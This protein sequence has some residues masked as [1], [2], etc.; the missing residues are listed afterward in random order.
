M[1]VLGMRD[2]PRVA[3]NTHFMYE[4][5]FLEIYVYLSES[6]YIESI[7][8]FCVKKHLHEICRI[9]FKLRSFSVVLQII[10][11]TARRSIP[12]FSPVL[13]LIPLWNAEEPDCRGRAW[14]SP[15]CYL[16]GVNHIPGKKR[17]FL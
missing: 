8:F 4:T 6:I 2:N 3:L 1:R 17:S 10:E 15:G 9:Y 13:G 14:S 7:S 5:I 16:R 11:K 12:R